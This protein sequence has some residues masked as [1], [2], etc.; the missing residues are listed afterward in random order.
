VILE[1]KLAGNFCERIFLG[2]QSL[3]AEVM[4]IKI[5]TKICACKVLVKDGMSGVLFWN[6]HS[7]GEVLNKN[8]NAKWVPVS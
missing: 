6:W 7:A 8:S 1:S 3:L 5:G 4:W 2:N